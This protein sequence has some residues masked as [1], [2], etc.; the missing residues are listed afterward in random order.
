MK[1]ILNR[2]LSR[3][4]EHP[5]RYKEKLAITST[6]RPAGT[7]LWMH[8]V[9]LGEV[10]ALRGL[11]EAIHCHRPDINFLI[12]SSTKTSAEVFAANLP[13]ST[14]HQFLPV[15]STPQIKTFLNH[16]QPDLSVW[17]EQDLWPAM[18]CHT[19]QQSIP[20]VLLNA[21]MN[22][23]SYRSRARLKSLYADLYKRFAWI[24]AQDDLTATHMASLG[25]EVT[26]G[27]SLKTASVPLHDNTDKRETFENNINGR[28]CWLLAS[29][30]RE[31]E[32]LALKAHHLLQQQHPDALLIIAPRVID[33]KEEIAE[34]AR[35][36]GF[37]TACRSDIQS[38][39]DCDV[40]IADT[41][42]EMGIWYRICRCAFIGGSMNDVQ[43]HNP[44]EAAVLGCAV[45][46][47]PNTA[48]F[49]SDYDTLQ[50]HNAATRVTHESQLLQT[51]TDTQRTVS[52]ARN[53]RLLAQNNNQQVKVLA[54]RLIQTLGERTHS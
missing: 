48:N 47:G 32:A 8:G 12:T 4:K 35:A 3:G 44:W 24:S 45:I 36:T 29:S 6:P 22:K 50:Q 2:R 15:D 18:V 52:T 31:D 54:N 39:A 38:A 14:T 37:T 19:H 10:L 7:L 46:H 1:W 26:V 42:G 51:L 33:R 49:Q 28:P 27:G 9:G 16:W 5:Q 17:A 30:H 41:F 25:A 43:G 53:A 20:L 21:R 34:S 23:K 40:Y 11:I 13:V